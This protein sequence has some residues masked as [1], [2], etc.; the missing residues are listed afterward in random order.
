MVHG[1]KKNRNRVTLD[2]V[3]GVLDGSRNH[4]SPLRGGFGVAL[5]NHSRTRDAIDPLI[6]SE[7]F[8]S[9]H[10]ILLLQ[11]LGNC[12]SGRSEVSLRG[13]YIFLRGRERFPLLGNIPDLFGSCGDVRWEVIGL[14]LALDVLQVSIHRPF[15]LAII[16]QKSAAVISQ[17]ADCLARHVGLQDFKRSVRLDEFFISGL[18]GDAVLRGLFGDLLE[19]GG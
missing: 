8:F 4:Q 11:L 15:E 1:H 19:W 9:D 12:Q 17:L 16:F 14:K 5:T 2:G 7:V 18:V 6:L 13:T 3:G 10:S